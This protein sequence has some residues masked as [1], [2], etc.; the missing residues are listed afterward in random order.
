MMGSHEP[1]PRLGPKPSSGDD[2]SLLRDRLA[3]T[4]RAQLHVEEE[5][6]RVED[7]HRAAAAEAPEPAP[8]ADARA[9]G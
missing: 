3:A 6:A 1:S 7:E 9:R 8:A 2:E 5:L 4:R